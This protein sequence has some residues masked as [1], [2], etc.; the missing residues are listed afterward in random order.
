MTFSDRLGITTPK[1]VLQLDSIDSEL[2][3]G[4]WEAC[5]EFYVRDFDVAGGLVGP[6]LRA[7]LRDIYLNHFKITTDNIEFLSN[8]EIT[9]QKEMFF[10]CD[11]FEAY[12]YLEFIS[13]C[14]SRAFEPRGNPQVP[15]PKKHDDSFRHRVNFFLEREKS[16]Y[17]FVGEVI[18]PISSTIEIQ[19]IEQALSAGDK[20]AGARSHIQHAVV[21][22]GKKPE[23]DYRNAVKEAISAVES[24]VR[25]ITS[26]PKATLGD[27][28]KKLDAIKTLHPAFK[29][30][31]DKLYGYTSDEGGIRHSLIDLSKVDEADAKFMIVTCSAFMNFCMQRS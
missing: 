30:A 28:L 3:S 1:H 24:A 23:P 16:A 15:D 29:Q 11:W 21:L 18:V 8:A 13:G 26:E 6:T 31:M 7:F 14:A 5:T 12:N 17:R 4:L 20:F 2:Q 10:R 27:A 19:S 9:K 22:F 25:V